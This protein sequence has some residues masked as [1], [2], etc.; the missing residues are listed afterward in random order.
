[1]QNK[2]NVCMCVHFCYTGEF[3]EEMDRM[4]LK[5]LKRIRSWRAT[6]KSI[7][8]M[9]ALWLKLLIDCPSMSTNIQSASAPG[10]GYFRT[11]DLWVSEVQG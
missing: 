6:E 3:K 10:G 5:S 1:M 11:E 9:M 4:S 2:V 8:I 7:S